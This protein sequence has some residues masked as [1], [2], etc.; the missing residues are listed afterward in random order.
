MGRNV[1]V[2]NL[3]LKITENLTH[4]MKPLDMKTSV[5]FDVTNKLLFNKIRISPLYHSPSP[6]IPFFFPSWKQI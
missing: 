5:K 4:K 6:E 3:L 2:P 1:I